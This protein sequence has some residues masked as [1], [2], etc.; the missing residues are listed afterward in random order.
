MAMRYLRGFTRDPLTSYVKSKSLRSAAEKFRLI[1]M[2]L[3]SLVK[4]MSGGLKLYFSE[5]EIL[6]VIYF[7]R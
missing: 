7:I 3:D 6:S 1:S 2:F 4:I 5:E